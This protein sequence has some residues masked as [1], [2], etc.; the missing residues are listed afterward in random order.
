MKPIEFA[1]LDVETTGF[2]KKLDRIV[3]IAIIRINS[4]GEFI[5]QYE[6]LVNP[7]RDVGA[8]AIHRISASDVVNAPIFED[9]RY[10]VLE[11]LNNSVIVS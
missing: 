7:Q 9:I 8:S 5:R 2:S 11:M 10:S 6:T 3:E 4:S 1:V